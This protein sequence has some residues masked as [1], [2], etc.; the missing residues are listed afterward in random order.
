MVIFRIPWDLFPLQ[1]CPVNPSRVSRRDLLRGSVALAAY[2]LASRP[3]RA[4]GLEPAPGE[5]LI[6]FLDPQPYDPK[7]PMLRWANLKD[8]VTDANDLYE[9]SH[10][11]KPTIDPA[12]KPADWKIEF[13]G[14]LRKPT[15]LT[16]ADLM[17]RPR[18]TLTATLEC[19]GNGSNP[20]FS[21]AC[22][23]I[24]WTGTPLGPVLRDLG[25]MQRSQEI[26]F[27]GSDEKVEKIRDRDFPQ[28]FARSLPLNHALQ[29]EVM[30]V[31]A[32]NG[33]PLKEIHGFPVRLI[34]PGWFGIAWVKWLKRVDVLDRRFMG[35]WMAREYVTIRGEEREDPKTTN[36]RETSVCNL[37]C[38]SV[39]ARA[40][41]RPDG[42]IRFSGAAWSD[43][44]TLKSVE[45]KLDDGRWEPATLERKP[46]RGRD[47][48]YTWSFW[49][50]DWK[51]PTPGDHS[52]VARATDVDGRVQPSADDPAIKNKATYW[53]ANQQW[54]RKLR[55][56]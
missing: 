29:D 20:G 31:W 13:T 55:V 12:T 27:Y 46:A 9:V 30:L 18:K 8:W 3:L 32:H 28:N 24:R 53:E 51:H 22:G 33:E 10:Y 21:G 41:R 14:Y 50:Y 38:K 49:H 43:G 37:C 42:S 47:T 56:E 52:V 40:V 35:K 26:V 16:L 2:T 15:T 7:R 4:F 5:V 39:T 11:P 48:K 1:G 6:P 23:N 36:W 45:V 19:G 54:I 17:K 44:T 25:L 34:V